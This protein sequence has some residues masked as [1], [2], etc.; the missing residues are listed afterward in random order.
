MVA[1]IV[2]LKLALMRNSLRRST[3]QLVGLVVGGLYALGV[4]V[5]CLAGLVALRFADVRLAGG[6]VTVAGAVFTLG[7]VLMPLL[8]FGVDQTLDPARF[9]TFAVPRRELLLGTLLAGLAGLPGLAAL[10][11]GLGTV[12]TFSRSVPAVLLALAGAVVGVLTCVALSR[13]VTTAASAVLKSR[14][15]SE[16]AAA[17]TG[18]LLV[19]MG[20]LVSLGSDRVRSLGAVTRTVVPV[21]AWTPLALPWAVGA[22]AARGAWASSAVRLALATGVLLLV[23][24]AWAG[25]L[26]RATESPRDTGTSSAVSTGPGW[27]ARLPGTT[28]GAVAAR[29]LTYWRRD[30]RYQ[31]AIGMLPFLP[32][33]LL[34]P[35]MVGS[36]GH[37]AL[38]LLMAPA[39]GYLLG[40]GMHNDL[41]YD[42]TAFWLHLAT[43]V[44]GRADRLGRVAPSAVLGG[45]LV[46]AYAAVGAAVAGRWDALPATLA[47]GLVLL[48]GGFGLSCVVS[49]LKPYPVPAAGDS[50]FH[51]PAGAS[52][53]TLLV[54]LASSTALTVLAAPVLALAAW[55]YWGDQAWLGWVALP[56]AAALGAAYL[57]LGVRTGARLFERRGPQLLAELTRA[58]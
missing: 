9:A 38:A 54:Q 24:R 12:V 26:Q 13:L 20:P 47:A 52:G 14:R 32:L 10:V 53:V 1:H 50:P 51:T 3:A 40:W 34:V 55:A 49:V 22:D 31:L 46:P 17:V 43:G 5:L 21:L 37:R 2:R 18:I 48:V 45:V 28:A 42:G 27:F 23:L 57:V 6:V 25:A 41:A 29:S 4:V 39:L 30:P 19:G 33:G 7:W 8:V 36:G 58:R 11:L 44:D 15:G 35:G 56:V 16:V